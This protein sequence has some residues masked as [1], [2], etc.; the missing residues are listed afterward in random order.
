MT[1]SLLLVTQLSMNHYGIKSRVFVSHLIDLSGGTAFDNV[2][3]ETLTNLLGEGL[4]VFHILQDGLG[5]VHHVVEFKQ[6]LFE[7]QEGMA[8]I[9]KVRKLSSQP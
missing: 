2:R 9:L 5:F 7:G 3:L 4:S 8:S 6:L 1:Q